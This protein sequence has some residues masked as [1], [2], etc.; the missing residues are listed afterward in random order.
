MASL[1]TNDLTD[2]QIIHNECARMTS[3]QSYEGLGIPVLPMHPRSK[4]P[5]GRGWQ[6]HA[7]DDGKRLYDRF[8]ALPHANVGLLMGREIRPH[9]YPFALDIDPRNEGK[10]GLRRLLADLGG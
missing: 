6:R 1:R 9:E 4:K 10:E 3:I 2:G 8:A 5:L 7:T